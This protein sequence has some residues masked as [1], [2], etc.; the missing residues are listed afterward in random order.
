MLTKCLACGGAGAKFSKKT[1]SWKRCKKCLGIG[2][3][4][5]VGQLEAERV[6]TERLN[7]EWAEL[8]DVCKAL[9]SKIKAIPKEGILK[10]TKAD[11]DREDKRTDIG[12]ELERMA[13]VIARVE[14]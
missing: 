14:Q 12:P 10:W 4:I 13:A 2:G 1:W 7:A 3:S 6:K 5:P 8:F 9:M 11:W